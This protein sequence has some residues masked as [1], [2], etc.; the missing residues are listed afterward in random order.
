VVLLAAP[1]ELKGDAAANL[2]ML[3]VCGCPV[4]QEIPAEARNATLVVDALLGTGVT[5]AASGRMLDAIR[6]I[7][8]GFPLAKV[9]AV[10]IPSAWRPIR[11][12]RRANSCAPITP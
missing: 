3:A 1:E 9:M 10:D 8:G 4:V 7:N 11:A 5:G 6:E 12:N 2:K